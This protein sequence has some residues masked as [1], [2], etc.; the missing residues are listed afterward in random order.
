M[1]TP[2]KWH[3]FGYHDLYPAGGMGDYLGAFATPDEA[4][5]FIASQVQRCGN[6]DLARLDDAGTLVHSATLG[7]DGQ[8]WE[9]EQ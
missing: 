5:E 7:F 3:L 4:R 8:W 1:T 6:Y 2:R 9:Q